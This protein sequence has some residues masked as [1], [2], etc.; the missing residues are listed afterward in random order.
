VAPLLNFAR[1]AQLHRHNTPQENVAAFAQYVQS[2]NPSAYNPAAPPPNA[3][4]DPNVAAYVNAY[5]GVPGQYNPLMAMDAANTMASLSGYSDTPIT[6]TPVSTTPQAMQTGIDAHGNPVMQTPAALTSYT[7]TVGPDGQL[8]R[9]LASNTAHS[10]AS[11]GTFNSSAAQNAYN[12]GHQALD[13]KKAGLELQGQQNQEKTMLGAQQALQTADAGVGK[14]LG[15]WAT[16]QQNN[17]ASSVQPTFTPKMSWATF[18]KKHGGKPTTA[19][20]AAW[21]AS[22]GNPSWKGNA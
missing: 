6:Q 22:F 8:Y 3:Y 1:F 14:S 5:M 11:H 17:A 7:F 4:V 20:Q 19:L 21:K 12:Q 15:S 18:V 13:I 10:Y 9:Q 2:H 16:Q